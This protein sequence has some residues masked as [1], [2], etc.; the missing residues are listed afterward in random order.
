MQG[1]GDFR[2]DRVNAFVADVTVDDLDETVLR[3]SVD[4]V[5]LVRGA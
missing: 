4:V 5:T 2:Y 3:D 1:H